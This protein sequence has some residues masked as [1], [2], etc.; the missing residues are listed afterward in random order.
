LGYFYFLMIY[1]IA[2]IADVFGDVLYYALG[3]WGGTSVIKR[4]GRYFKF[5]E[6]RL[7]QLEQHFY[8]HAGKTLLLGK[9]AHGIGG[10][11][12]VAAGTAK[13]PLGKFIWYNFLG[14]LPKSLILLLIGYYFGKT[15]AKFSTYLD[16][17][18]LGTAGLTIFLL[19]LYLSIKRLAKKTL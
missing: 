5:T 6:N 19:L 18:A 7:N 15:Y 10:A 9:L 17:T 2:I 3:R 8:Q 13:M 16:Y 11:I 1:L 14:T 4:W 12:L